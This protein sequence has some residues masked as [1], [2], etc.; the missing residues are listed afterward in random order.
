[1]HIP[2]RLAPTMFYVFLLMVDLYSRDCPLRAWVS[3]Y[4]LRCSKT[5][6]F[7]NQKRHL[8]HGLNLLPNNAPVLS[9]TNHNSLS[10]M[11][12]AK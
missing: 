5:S 9:Y 12:R 2:V 6:S 3:G 7:S 8:H 4:K 11:L 10:G 1:M